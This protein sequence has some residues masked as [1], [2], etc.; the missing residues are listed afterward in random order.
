MVWSASRQRGLLA[1]GAPLRT[2]LPVII[3]VAADADH[4]ARGTGR[5]TDDNRL[6]LLLRPSITSVPPLLMTMMLLAMMAAALAIVR[7]PFHSTVA[8]VFRLWLGLGVDH[9]SR[10]AG[11]RLQD[12]LSP[13]ATGPVH[14]LWRGATRGS[15]GVCTMGDVNTPKKAIRDIEKYYIG[16]RVQLNLFSRQRKKQRC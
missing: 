6:L 7:V 12:I 4:A 9:H 15:Q 10:Q 16:T 14:H 5:I 8:P 1:V 13:C 2:V 3:R 11:R